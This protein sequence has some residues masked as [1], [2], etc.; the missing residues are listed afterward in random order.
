M[1]ETISYDVFDAVVTRA[2]AHPRDL[3]V[4]VGE[5]AGQPQTGVPPLTFAQ[6][7][8]AAELATRARTNNSEVQLGEIYGTLATRLR[9]QEP[10]TRAVQQIE[11]EVE[12][13]LLRAVPHMPAE[14]AAARR[15]AGRILFLSD[16]YLPSAVL[17]EWLAR[18]GVMAPP[19]RL[20]ISGEMR[21]NK[22]SGRLFEAVRNAV[23]A[24]Y[25]SWHHAGDHP[26]ADVEKPRSL[27]MQATPLPR[28]HL[29]PREWR[30][31]GTKGEFAL[32]WRSLLAGAIRLARLEHRATGERAAVLWEVGTAVAGP[33]F[34]GFIRWTLQEAARRGLR[35]LYFLARDGQ[36]FFRI[37]Q[38]IQRTEGGTVECRYLQVSRLVLAGPTEMESPAILRELI[39]PGGNFHSLSQAVSYLG[40]ARDALE[41]PA[42]F[43][44]LDPDA[45]LAPALRDALADWLMLP[46]QLA[47]AQSALA[48]RR[49][50]TRSYLIT[51]GL[52]DGQPCGVVDAGWQG[53]SQKNLERILG[54]GSRPVPLTGFYLGLMPPRAPA[55]AGEMIGY[56]NLFG[57]LPLRRDES[58]KVLIELMAQSDHGQVAGFQN[59]DGRCSPVL[60]DPGPVNLEEIRFLQGAI[61][62]FT[63][64]MLEV[65]GECAMPADAS[66]RVVLANYRAFH[67]R[68]SLPE[69]RVF[70]RMPHADQ[71]FD[72]HHASLCAALPLRAT[73]RALLNHRLRPPHWWLQGE[74]ACG[75]AWLLRTFIALKACRWR[76]ARRA[77]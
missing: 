59:V 41:L 48:V 13:R 42:R 23:G 7:R 75:H 63:R 4:R 19:D 49:A 65:R 55:A 76:L 1:S 44:A 53:T 52:G 30:V 14:L 8:W 15:R 69:A 18:L 51:E 26:F 6:A 5:I 40:L 9:W 20:F 58:H 16:M 21:G 71:V 61:L 10:T 25:G 2:V 56:A 46:P 77:G 72:Q 73:L 11:L 12:A 24:D 54:D 45:N 70:G 3:F 38:E 68:P 67:D 29:T 64:R 66:A 35:R 22:S 27:G 34:Y 33:L 39:A 31:R 57:P 28:V 74:A 50:Q 37:A 36:V 62:A 17:G 47:L 43:A 32:P 60:R